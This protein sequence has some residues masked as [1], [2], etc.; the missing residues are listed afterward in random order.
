VPKS[1]FEVQ[2][3]KGNTCL[4]QAVS[5]LHIETVEVLIFEIGVDPDTKCEMGNTVLHK[6]LMIDAALPPDK[7]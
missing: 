3:S 4:W 5:N 6:A 1:D 2:D 7:R